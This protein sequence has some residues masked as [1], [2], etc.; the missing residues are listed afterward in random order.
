ML[1]AAAS[2]QKMILPK[3]MESEFKSVGKQHPL[4]DSWHVLFDFIEFIINLVVLKIP[5]IPESVIHRFTDYQNGNQMTD[6]ASKVERRRP[7]WGR[8]RSWGPNYTQH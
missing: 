4:Y 3:A 8:S 6:L 1:N 7:R 5:Q 2:E